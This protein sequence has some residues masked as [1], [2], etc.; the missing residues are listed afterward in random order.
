MVRNTIESTIGTAR[1]QAN[2]I[3]DPV[4]KSADA[5]E[6]PRAFKEKRAPKWLGY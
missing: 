5:Q 3:W 4:Y 1:S 2:E 6:G